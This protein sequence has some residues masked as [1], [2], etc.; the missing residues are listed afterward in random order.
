[1][2]QCFRKPYEPFGGDINIK[3]DLSDCTTKTNLRKA[4]G[5]D[6]S[7]LALK[8]N[9]VKLKAEVDKIDIEKSK[10]VPDEL[11]KLSNVVN[12]EVIKKTVCDKLAA[13]VNN[14][15]TSGFVLKTIN[16]T[17]INQV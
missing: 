4:T 1:M 15:D 5:I 10:T 9:L 6:T 13:K 11:R 17:Q 16:M 3:V 14:L 8:L 7:N 2:S 12:N